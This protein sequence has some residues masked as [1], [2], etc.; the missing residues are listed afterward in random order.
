LT[1]LPGNK[2]NRALHLMYRYRRHNFRV[3][4]RRK[5]KNEIIE[6][7]R[8]LK[9]H[10]LGQI[11]LKAKIEK[12]RK[13]LQSLTVKKWRTNNLRKRSDVLNKTPLGKG[14]GGHIVLDGEWK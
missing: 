10:P 7:E 2:F 14:L 12:R 1:K 3:V 13:E 11:I 9:L 6:L 4:Q 5:L 8:Q